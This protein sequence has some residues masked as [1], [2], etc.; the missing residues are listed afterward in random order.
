[1]KSLNKSAI[2][3][4][5][6][7]AFF[8]STVKAAPAAY[9]QSWGESVE[10][11]ADSAKNQALYATDK[12]ID[13]Q[14]Q[15][16][17]NSQ[18]I[19]IIE[20]GLMNLDTAV[21]NNQNDIAQL[22]GNA[23]QTYNE[24]ND[25]NN[26]NDQQD[27]EI[28]QLSGGI[29]QNYQNIQ[30]LTDR[31]NNLPTPKD[32]VDGKDGKDGVNG[33]DGATGATGAT[34]AQGVQGLAGA[35]GKDGANGK[36]GS[37]GKNGSDGVTTTITK[38]EVDQATQKAVAG[39][40]QQ[41]A[42]QANAFKSLKDTV[43]SNHK[44]ANAGISGAMAMAGLPQ[45]QTNQRVMFSAGGATYNGESAL[46]VGGSVNFNSHVV[47]KVSFSTDTASNMGASVGVGVGF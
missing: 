9:D 28:N 7:G 25:I 45:V 5:V 11:T 17:Q 47:G 23:Q 18:D 43:D 38:V 16:A 24:I 12:A 42:K 26:K 20:G 31:L 22:K 10:T 30:G 13:A 21:T 46:A 39:L 33:K 6:F 1:M 14:N 35:A 3:F 41:Q 36:D 32:G 40:Q 37:N 8:A 19:T 2:V 34:G 29:Q 4:F 27:Q 15:A 44:Q